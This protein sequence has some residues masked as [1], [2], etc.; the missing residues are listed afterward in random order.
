[1]VFSRDSSRLASASSDAT[2]RLWDASSG[3]CLQTYTGH[4]SSVMSV[5]F[6]HDSSKLASASWDN[7]VKVWDASSDKCVRTY[8]GHSDAVTSVAFS[9]NSSKLAS[10][11][12]DKTVK[13]WDASSGAC[14]QTLN[15]GRTIYSLSFDSTDSCLHTEIGTVVI[16]IP[17]TSSEVTAA[18]AEP[19]QYLGTSLS[20]D[21]M[22]IK[23]RDKNMLWIPSEY[24][25]SC[26]SVRGTTVAMGVGSGRV[27]TCTIDV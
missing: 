21:N 15:I 17:E 3:A 26:S 24:R 2:I 22:W 13:L 12:Y 10:A 14:L 27:W 8:T 4:S 16:S 23:H 19:P 25:P 20:S 6:S 1:V 18:E 11:S 7:T 9:H 5:A